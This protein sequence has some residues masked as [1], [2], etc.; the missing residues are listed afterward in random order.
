MAMHEQR[1]AKSFVGLVA[2][3]SIILASC[4]GA[5][6]SETEVLA[7]QTERSSLTSDLPVTTTP[8]SEL[9]S[10]HVEPPIN[11]A[12]SPST[13][14]DHYPFWM[15]CGFYE[16][17]VIEGAATHSLEHG[18]VWIT[19]GPSF[20][21][22]DL[23]ELES[24]AE[25]NSRLLISPYAHEEPIVLSVWGAQLRSVTSAMDLE[26]QLFIDAWQDNLLLAEAGARCNGSLGVA[27]DIVDRFPDG[28]QI[29]E[30]FLQ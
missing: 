13:G 8:L 29:P 7:A 19:Y 30:L 22:R 5:E 23:S 3:V 28:Q 24:L 1:I 6:L 4:G 20:P 15:N 21:E 14:G 2:G 17:P 9:S 10:E 27:P 16:V 26:I 11:F 12:T 18:V 25:N